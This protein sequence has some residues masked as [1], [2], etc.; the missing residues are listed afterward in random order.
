M[1]CLLSSPVLKFF[2]RRNETE[3]LRLREGERKTFSEVNES[4]KTRESLLWLNSKSS[5]SISGTLS[6]SI[7]N[8]SPPPL[9]TA[10]LF[11]SILIHPPP[12]STVSWDR[13]T[14]LFFG[15][16]IC[17]S[18]SLFLSICVNHNIVIRDMMWQLKWV[19]HWAS[20]LVGATEEP[21]LNKSTV[22]Y[23][24]R[25]FVAVLLLKM[26]LRPP[27]TLPV[28]HSLNRNTNK[29]PKP[30]FKASNKPFQSLSST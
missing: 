13:P 2:H 23:Y 28:D 6:I 22:N 16:S 12:E 29:L 26:K 9:A 20:R 27:L 8:L 30:I 17:S 24:R 11:I 10:L 15:V 14:P 5:V 18:A 1:N 4:D 21:H 7:F 3:D 19:R 25:Y